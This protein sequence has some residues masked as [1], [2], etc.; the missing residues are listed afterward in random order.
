MKEYKWDKTKDKVLKETRGVSFSDILRI[1][2]TKNYL[3]IVEN[4]N[5]NHLGQ[6]MYIVVI[7]NYVYY[8]P[9]VEDSEKIFL[10]TIIPSR[11][12]TKKYIKNEKKN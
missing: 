12:L 10:K 4:T 11:K 7:A 3:D 2:E 1:L 9:F 5:K 8:I 6:K